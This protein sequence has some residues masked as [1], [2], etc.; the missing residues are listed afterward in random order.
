MQWLVPDKRV[1][2]VFAEYHRQPTPVAV[3][4]RARNYSVPISVRQRVR[5]RD[6]GRCVACGAR[7]DLAIHHIVPKSV[8]WDLR[9]DPTNLELRCCD[10]HR[11]S[12]QP[13]WLA[14][15]RELYQKGA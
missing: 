11:L 3:I 15:A 14:Q 12:H 13:G 2:S 7:N 10:C 4:R 8:R 1:A 5:Q 6:K 9:K